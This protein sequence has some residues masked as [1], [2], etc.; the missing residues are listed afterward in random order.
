MLLFFDGTK[1]ARPAVVSC[2]GLK[3]TRSNTKQGTKIK[4]QLTTHPLY[5]LRE[6]N[7]KGGQKL[8][9]IRKNTRKE[10]KKAVCRDLNPR[11]SDEQGCAKNLGATFGRRNGGV[12]TLAEDL[13]RRMFCL[14][15]V[16]AGVR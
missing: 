1:N 8:G 7:K 4:E 3:Y 14:G 9:G 12:I 16:Q 5:Y 10:E 15:C 11:P 2:H 13:F 6:G